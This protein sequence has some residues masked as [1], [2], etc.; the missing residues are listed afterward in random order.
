M[1]VWDRWVKRSNAHLS[2]RWMKM[3]IVWSGSYS[4]TFCCISLES[5]E[6]AVVAWTFLNNLK[7]YAVRFFKSLTAFQM[8]FYI[9]Q[10]RQ[11]PIGDPV[12]PKTNSTILNAYFRTNKIG[13]PEWNCQHSDDQGF[14]FNSASEKTRD[15]IKFQSK[16]YLL[17]INYLYPT[18]SFPLILSTDWELYITVMNLFCPVRSK[19]FPNWQTN[20]HILQ[21]CGG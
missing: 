3:F 15:P 18:P 4:K 16:A 10:T 14:F 20:G 11:Q 5:R 19:E 7:C 13:N 17:M 9:P 8:Y 12:R 2:R 1:K 21:Y 6:S